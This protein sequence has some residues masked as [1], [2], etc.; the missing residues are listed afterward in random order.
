MVKIK[1]YL[2]GMQG[3]FGDIDGPDE[4]EPVPPVTI[5]VDHLEPLKKMFGW[6]HCLRPLKQAEAFITNIDFFSRVFTLC[7]ISNQSG[8]CLNRD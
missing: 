5:K 6:R 3:L 8:F 1:P 2:A 7:P 4:K